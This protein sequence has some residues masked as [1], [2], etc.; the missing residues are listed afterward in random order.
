[1]GCFFLAILFFSLIFFL[2]K[3]S[4]T[5]FAYFRIFEGKLA[6]KSVQKI[7][8]KR[9]ISYPDKKSAPPNLFFFQI[10]EK[11]Y[12]KIGGKKYLKIGQKNI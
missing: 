3:F 6:K 9:R 10:D 12:L 4:S 2:A 11:K 5:L 8:E 1:M 7:G